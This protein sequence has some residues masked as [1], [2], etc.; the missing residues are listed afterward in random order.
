MSRI[1]HL[2]TVIAQAS[3]LFTG[4]CFLLTMALLPLVVP[5]GVGSGPPPREPS[6]G[7]AITLIVFFVVPAALGFWWIFRRLRTKYP[8]R[9]ALGAALGFAVF[10]PVPLIIGLAVG[11]IVGGYADI[12]LRTESPSVAFWGAVLGIVVIIALITLVPSLLALWI[13]RRSGD[14]AHQT[15]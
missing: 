11:P 9:Q 12:F 5:Q 3:F 10:A 7:Q 15:R 13:T 1:F 4:T 14:E 2:F 6:I 8:R